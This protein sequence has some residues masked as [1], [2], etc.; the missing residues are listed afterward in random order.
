M[1]AQAGHFT[2]EGKEIDIGIRRQDSLEI[3]VE[4]LRAWLIKKLSRATF[5]RSAS[6]CSCRTLAATSSATLCACVLSTAD[7]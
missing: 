2:L 6:T 7:V 3:K 5:Q 1:Q 4:A